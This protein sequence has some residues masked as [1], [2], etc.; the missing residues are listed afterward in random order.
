MVQVILSLILLFGSQT[1]PTRAQVERF[2][3]ADRTSEGVYD[4]G[5]HDCIEFSNELVLAARERGIPAW[6]ATVQ[7]EGMPIGHAFVAIRTSDRGMIWVEPQTD[8][9]FVISGPGSPLCTK[10]GWCRPWTISKVVYYDAL[11]R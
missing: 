8:Q 3:Q 2:L 11:V 4:Y 6:V 10:I 5:V 1:L 9:E 7:F